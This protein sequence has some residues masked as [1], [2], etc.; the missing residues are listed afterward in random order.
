MKKLILTLATLT[1]LFTACKKEKESEEIKPSTQ[2]TN[3]ITDDSIAYQSLLRIEY[4]T[5][6]REMILSHSIKESEAQLG[7]K[8]TTVA[9]NELQFK[10]EFGS[11]YKNNIDLTVGQN[12]KTTGKKVGDAFQIITTADNFQT[13][14]IPLTV[15]DKHKVGKY[16]LVTCQFTYDKYTFT[17]TYLTK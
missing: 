2:L 12:A 3:H 9:I 6:N 14:N 7:Y 11:E 15:K 13:Y 16:W 10:Y 5:V 1:V 8:V 4:D 17:T